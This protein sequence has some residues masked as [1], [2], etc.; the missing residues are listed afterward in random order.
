MGPGS[1]LGGSKLDAADAAA[2]AAGR[3]EVRPLR[4]EIWPWVVGDGFQSDRREQRSAALVRAALRLAVL[5]QAI[6]GPNRRSPPLRNMLEQV[7]A[8]GQRGSDH[9]VLYRAEHVVDQR[10]H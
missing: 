6:P 4:H 9:P 7:A 2:L 3:F 8:P 1:D 10:L 5:R